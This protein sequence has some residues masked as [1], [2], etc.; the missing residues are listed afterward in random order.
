MASCVCSSRSC[1][2]TPSFTL[3]R[4]GSGDGVRK[5]DARP[6]VRRRRQRRHNLLARI[7]DFNILLL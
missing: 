4:F 6:S 2:C 7:P 5:R 1:A 3:V